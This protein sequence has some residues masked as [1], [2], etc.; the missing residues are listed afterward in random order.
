MLENEENVDLGIDM[1]GRIL[2]AYPSYR[3]HLISRIRNE[4]VWSNARVYDFGKRLIIPSETEVRNAPWFGVDQ[5]YSFSKN[6]TVT[7]MFH[8]MRD[9]IAQAGRLDDFR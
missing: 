6:G 3:N 1:M 2:K 7:A 9:G 5:I 4:D 8:R